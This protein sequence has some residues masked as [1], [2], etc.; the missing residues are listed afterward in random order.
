MATTVAE[1]LKW[2][3]IG[4]DSAISICIL[5]ESFN[6]FRAVM[7][8]QVSE[9]NI[10]Q[11]PNRQLQLPPHTHTTTWLLASQPQAALNQAI[12]WSR[13]HFTNPSVVQSSIA[14]SSSLSKTSHLTSPSPPSLFAAE[15]FRISYVV[16][17]E[18]HHHEAAWLYHASSND[19]WST[20]NS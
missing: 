13:A 9:F 5:Q 10:F 19:S 11:A 7:N 2:L 6:G 14:T 8:E 3:E 20:R 16:G 18:M 17:I 4:L 15:S 12:L 1:I